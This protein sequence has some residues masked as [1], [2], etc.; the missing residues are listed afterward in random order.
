MHEQFQAYG[1]ID[2]QSAF[3]EQAIPWLDNN[4]CVYRYAYFGVAD[5]NQSLLENGGP[6]LS[7]LGVQYTFTPYGQAS[8]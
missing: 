4:S 5:P 2:E 7:A 6:A 1:T 8:M 3:L